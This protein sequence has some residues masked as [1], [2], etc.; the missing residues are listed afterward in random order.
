MAAMAEQAERVI[1]EGWMTKHPSQRVCRTQSDVVGGWHK[2]WF[3]LTNKRL[4]YYETVSNPSI[5]ESRPR[6]EL[7]LEAVIDV[8][9]ADDE[10]V[11]DECRYDFRVDAN[12]TTW[13]LRTKMLKD[14]VSWMGMIR[15][16]V[17]QARAV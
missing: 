4:L 11:D 5:K 1:Q 7:P 8:S 6:G 16:A 3:V 14:R 13:Q 17:Q 2:R 10:P 15:A 12:G 9:V